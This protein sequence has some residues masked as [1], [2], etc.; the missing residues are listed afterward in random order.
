MTS[1]LN[2]LTKPES[3]FS[4]PPITFKHVVLP[5]PEGPNKEKNSPSLISNWIF[6]NAIVSLNFLLISFNSLYL[7]YKIL[8]F[9]F[10]FV[11]EYKL[12]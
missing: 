6:F 7:W 9:E 2:K 1:L 8:N 11:S 10:W 12:L 5:D 4:N 3:G